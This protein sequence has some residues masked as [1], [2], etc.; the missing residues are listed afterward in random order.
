LEPRGALELWYL[1]LHLPPF[2]TAPKEA[3]GLLGKESFSL[4]CSGCFEAAQARVGVAIKAYLF[5][6][7][8]LE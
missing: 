2:E 5:F 4:D 3:S 7:I 6:V 8:S 1:E